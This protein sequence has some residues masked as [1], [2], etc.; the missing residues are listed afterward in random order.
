MDRAC[1]VGVKVD[2]EAHCLPAATTSDMGGRRQCTD[3]A[4]PPTF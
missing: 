4:P 3:V 2:L 1:S